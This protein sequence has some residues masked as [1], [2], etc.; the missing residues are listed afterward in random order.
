MSFSETLSLAPT[1]STPPRCKGIGVWAVGLLAVTLPWTTS[2]MLAESTAKT[3][4]SVM[5]LGTWAGRNNGM[6]QLVFCACQLAG[7]GPG[8]SQGQREGEHGHHL[9]HCSG[10]CQHGGPCLVPGTRRTGR[11]LWLWL[12]CVARTP[13]PPTPNIQVCLKEREH[14][15][16]CTPHCGPCQAF[17]CHTKDTPHS[18]HHPPLTSIFMT[19]KSGTGGL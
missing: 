12:S 15:C 5:E 2:R 7:G 11:A 6:M 4:Y 13:P 8:Q 3:L 17:S 16:R 9:P 1:K 10:S 19:A 14:C 18:H